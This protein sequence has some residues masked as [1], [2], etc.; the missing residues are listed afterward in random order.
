M[1]NIFR[2][3]CA[4]IM[5]CLILIISLV[6]VYAAGGAVVNGQGVNDG[7]KVEYTLSI[8]DTTQKVVGI[9]MF[10][11]YDQSVL[12]LEDASA[13]V[14]TNG[15][16]NKNQ[17]NDGL[18]HLNHSMLEGIDCKE[19]TEIIKVNF[20]VIG[21]GNADITY[22]IQYLYDYDNVN[23]Y[24]YTITYDLKVDDKLV[25]DN[26]SPVLASPDHVFAVVD[27]D[28]S[29]DFGDF[30][31]N[32]EGTGSGKKENPVRNEFYKDSTANADGSG[33]SNDNTG[34]NSGWMIG[35]AI[36]VGV[37]LV[38]VIVVSVVLKK[39]DKS[40]DNTTE[41]DTEE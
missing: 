36:A 12:K 32:V 35:I 39:K 40:E 31:N 5:A 13:S 1:K 3:S 15:M 2:A 17:N 27:D 9:Q 21:T 33:T 28:A 37:A 18:I 41:E 22:F 34:D 25:V 38:A 4:G 20:E 30:A 6:S 11:Q 16:M 8:A 14:F 26:Q 23:I 7:G 24:N 29:F 10:V 19:K